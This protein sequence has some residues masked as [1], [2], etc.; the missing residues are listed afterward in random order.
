MHGGER[1]AFVPIKKR[2]ILGEAFPQRRGFLDEIR[3]MAGLWPID[4][5]FQQAGVPD[6]R[7]PS[8]SLDLVSVNDEDFGKREEIPHCASFLYSSSYFLRLFR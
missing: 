4:C 1:R 7:C 2:V 3:V 8:V 6:S 5:R